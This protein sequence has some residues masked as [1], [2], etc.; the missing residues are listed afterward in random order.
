MPENS[1]AFVVVP[2]QKD[3]R[4]VLFDRTVEV[5]GD[6][7]ADRCV[8]RG[9]DGHR[10]NFLRKPRADALGYLVTCNAFL[11]GPDTTVRKCNVNHTKN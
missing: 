3:D 6:S 2:L 11:E 5:I 4:A 9:L 10:Q 8:G 1:L 7:L